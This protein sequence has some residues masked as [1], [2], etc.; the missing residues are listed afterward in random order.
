MGPPSYEAPITEEK[1]IVQRVI[2]VQSFS[3]FLQSSLHWQV[4][5]LCNPLTCESTGEMVSSVLWELALEVRGD[6]RPYLLCRRP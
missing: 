5:P 1:I 4:R 3:Y 6:L 2:A